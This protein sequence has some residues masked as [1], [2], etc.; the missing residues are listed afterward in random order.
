[1]NKIILTAIREFKATA[2]TPAFLFGAVILPVVIW[3]VLGAAGAAGL[4]SQQ[5]EPTQGTIAL[6]DPTPDQALTELVAARLDPETQKAKIEALKAEAQER[7]TQALGTVGE[8][9]A[10]Q[11]GN[12]LRIEPSEINVESLDTGAD[13]EIV[14]QRVRDG[15]L[16]ALIEV[17]ETTF[18]PGG[19]FTSQVGEKAKARDI[20][21]IEDAVAD[22]VVDVRL[23]DAGMSAPLV[24]TLYRRPGAEQKTLKTAGGETTGSEMVQRFLP[25][26]FLVFL[27][28]AIFTGGGYLLMSTVEE[29]SSRIMEVLLSSMSPMQLMTGKIIGQ[30]FVGLLLL[31]IYGGLG[32]FAAVQFAFMDLIPPSLLVWLVVYFLMGY[33]IYAS[34]NAAIGAAVNEAREAQALQGP[35]MGLTILIIYLAI[36]SVMVADNPHSSLARGLSYFPLATPFVMSMRVAYINDPMPMW[37]LASTTAVGV[38]GMVVSVWAAAKIFRVGVLMYGQPPSLIGLIKWMRYA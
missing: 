17:T 31:L 6:V 34:I 21:L 4:F 1:M 20:D 26:A 37:E 32:V 24:R 36:F 8:N 16:L 9:A 7:L 2:L 25:I 38:L 12:F 19:T 28:I 30:G 22:S 27:A 33:F 13:L 29:K 35:I 3:G 18:E 15:E 14:R 10:S 23:T 11:A 5:P